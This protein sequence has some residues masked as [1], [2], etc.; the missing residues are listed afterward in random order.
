MLTRD[1]PFVVPNQTHHCLGLRGILFQGVTFITNDPPPPDLLAG[2]T[3]VTDAVV[4]S[5]AGVIRRILGQCG[6][7]CH[8]DGVSSQDH[9]ISLSILTMVRI[10]QTWILQTP[11][12]L[13]NPLAHQGYMT[14]SSMTLETTCD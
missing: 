6:V 5:L 9:R 10:N 13:F 12:G 8:D 14:L 3:V 7:R 1:G 2:R 11:L 4:S